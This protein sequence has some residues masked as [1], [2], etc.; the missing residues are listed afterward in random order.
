MKIKL[1]NLEDH[2]VQDGQAS[3]RKTIDENYFDLPLYDVNLYPNRKFDGSVHV[4]LWKHESYGNLGY[5]EYFKK[6]DEANIEVVVYCVTVLFPIASMIGHRVVIEDTRI[7][8]Q[9]YK[10]IQVGTFL[11]NRK[12]CHA[13][14][15]KN[16]GLTTGPFTIQ[17]GLKDFSHHNETYKIDK[18]YHFYKDKP[19]YM[20][21]DAYNNW[22]S[23]VRS[24]FDPE[25]ICCEVKWVKYKK[26]VKYLESRDDCIGVK[27]EFQ[28][29]IIN[30]YNGN[31]CYLSYQILSSLDLG[32]RYIGIAG[33]ASLLSLALPVNLIFATD[34]LN[35]VPEH[36]FYFKSL[37][38]TERY[39][40]STVGFMHNRNHRM[41]SASSPL[42]KVYWSLE[43]E[44]RMNVLKYCLDNAP[45]V[46]GVLDVDPPP[47]KS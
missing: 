13:Y 37:M 16:L 46:P 26:I 28:K 14:A 44:W 4:L 9:M 30:E 42:P 3:Y 19:I 27:K 39:N 31:Q 29:E 8:N 2:K 1:I 33:A 6:M 21:E 32:C 12:R 35:N 25:K 43:Q 17:N 7:D 36:M 24:A 41:G 15:K 38:N 18:L 45:I 40:W 20:I 11:L 5:L 47:N 34:H 22:M 10:K 23:G